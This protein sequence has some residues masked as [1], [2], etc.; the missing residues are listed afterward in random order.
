M[1]RKPLFSLDHVCK[2]YGVIKA[3]SIESLVLYHEEMVLITGE[4]GTG[5]STLLRV[6]GGITRISDGKVNRSIELKTKRIA[7][8]PQ[9]GGLYPN[10][11]LADNMMI[12]SR[13]YD[14]SE[15]VSGIGELL[16]QLGLEDSL[17]R[18]VIDLS[19]GQQK[20]AVLISALAVAPDVLLLDEPL[21]GLDEIKS[22]VILSTIAK[23]SKNR[24]LTVITA[25]PNLKLPFE[26]R[27]VEL[28]RRESY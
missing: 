28:P 15:P 12:W 14:L 23:T 6:L 25:H 19:G 11:S 13:L 9:Y 10:L 22:D 1:N 2:R 27:R 26:F 3:L 4:N 18:K 24:L 21:S 8:V 20:L 17:N 16:K 7:F 5:K